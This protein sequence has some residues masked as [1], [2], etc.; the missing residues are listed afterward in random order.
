MSSQYTTTIFLWQMLAYLHI[1]ALQTDMFR[2]PYPCYYTIMLGLISPKPLAL[3]LMWWLRLNTLEELWTVVQDM[4]AHRES[5]GLKCQAQYIA[6]SAVCPVLLLPGDLRAWCRFHNLFS[7]FYSISW[8]MLLSVI[9]HYP[10]QADKQQCHSSFTS[11]CSRTSPEKTACG[12]MS[13]LSTDTIFPQQL[14]S[15]CCCNLLLLVVDSGA[16]RCCFLVD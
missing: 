7:K 6:L 1:T 13:L 4:Q 14:C 5:A 11:C 3:S 2:C 9:P 15:G 12:N 8:S 16:V 10:V